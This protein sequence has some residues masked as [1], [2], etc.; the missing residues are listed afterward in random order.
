MELSSLMRRVGWICF[1]AM[2]VPFT[3][4]FI[5]MIGLPSGEYAWAELP[6]LTRYSMLA[7]GGFFAATFIFLFG[8]PVVSWLNNRVVLDEGIAA[9]AEILQIWDT[10]TTINNHPVVR[11][12][13][14]VRPEGEPEFDAEAEKL[15]SRVRVPQYQPG[16]LVRVKYDPESF[17]VALFEEDG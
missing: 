13:V 11:F 9:D 12:L 14:R 16:S 17:Q 8:A 4:V 2:W 5:G 1:I 6:I 7:T 3:G 10:G 15:V